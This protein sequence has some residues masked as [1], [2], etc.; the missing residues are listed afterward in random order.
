MGIL[1]QGHLSDIK[2]AC[3]A[4]SIVNS[5]WL[6]SV[7]LSLPPQTTVSWYISTP[8]YAKRLIGV[9][10]CV[11]HLSE[12]IFYYGHM[13]RLMTVGLEPQ[14]QNMLTC[15]IQRHCFFRY[16]FLFSTHLLFSVC[17][18]GSGSQRVIYQ[19]SEI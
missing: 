12:W 2:T 9:C 11:C 19:G 14:R 3:G 17:V 18:C 5:G 1:V 13:V 8:I 16:V 15:H 10:L 6:V 7:C 4:C